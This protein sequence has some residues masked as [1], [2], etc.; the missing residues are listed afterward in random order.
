MMTSVFEQGSTDSIITVLKSV[1]GVAKE[2]LADHAV[3]FI[4]DVAFM[5]AGKICI[6]AMPLQASTT[7]QILAGKA[8]SQ[9]Y[10][11]DWLPTHTGIALALRASEAWQ[12]CLYNPT[13]WKL[14][15]ICKLDH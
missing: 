5:A 6:R 14:G 10:L 4:V 1:A 11:I 2:P 12:G 8:E 9:L 13:T 15:E 7:V 3:M